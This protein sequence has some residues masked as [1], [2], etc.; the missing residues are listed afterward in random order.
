ME[1]A[2][3]GF[4]R[5]LEEF[6]LDNLIAYAASRN[7]TDIFLKVASPPGMRILGKIVK[8]D[9]PVITPEDAV[10][11]AS[12]HMQDAQRKKF[13]QTREM[14]LSF[15]VPGVARIRQNVYQEKNNIATTCRLISLGVR[16]LDEIGVHSE[17]IKNLTAV[18][19]GLVLVTGPTGAGKTTTL[20]GMIEHININKPVNI[21]SIEDPIEYIYTDKEA[22]ISQREVGIDTLSFEEALKQVLRQT[23]DV[24]VIGEMRDVHTLNVAL[25]AAETGHLVFAT[26]HTSSA[27]ETLDRISNMYPPHERPLL[28]L[29]LSVCLKGVISQKLVTKAD[30]SGRLAAQEILI[31]TPTISKLLEEGKSEDLYT[32]MRQDGQEA[33]WGMQTMNQALERYVSDS[34]ISQEEALNKSGNLSELKQMLRRIGGGNNI[35]A[36]A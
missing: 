16:T 31:S 4:I 34:I 18:P 15:T 7:A 10:R 27:A 29:R 17:A 26:I 13:E 3:N 28:W 35:R 24:I 12:T 8:T 21:I 23:P 9:F 33:Y 5:S 25:Q 6:S 32:L 20:A 14:N 30:G 1:I 2:S 19:N 36:A 11:L 22:Q